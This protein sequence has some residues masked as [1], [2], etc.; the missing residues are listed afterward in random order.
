MKSDRNR[1]SQVLVNFASNAAKFTSEGHVEIGYYL[2][3]PDTI[4]FYVE[5]TGIGIPTEMHYRI[6]DR[7]TKV[8]SFSQGAGVGL[9]IS[10]AII[11]HLGGEIGV[12]SEP[13]KGSTFWF[14]IPISKS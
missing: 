11:H 14:E 7:F 12:D 4:R 6:F 9:E 5:D 13:G 10:R 8:N 2:I 1:L 3:S